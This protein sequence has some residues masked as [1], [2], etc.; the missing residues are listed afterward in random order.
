[1]PTGP[2]RAVTAPSAVFA[3]ESFI[4]ELAHA[5]G[6]DPITF[7]IER[8]LPNR[9]R[10]VRVLEELRRRSAWGT[11]VRPIRG[12]LVGRGVA[13]NVYDGTSFIAMM[14]EVS[15]EA[16]LS[17]LRVTRIITVVDCGLALNP[18]GVDGQT[19]SAIAWGLSAAL[20]GKIDFRNGAAMQSSYRDFPVL[21]IDRM[22]QLE[23]IV[24]NSS[25]EPGG[26]GE[27]PVPLVAPA[28][29]NAIFAAC[30]K[31]VRELPIEL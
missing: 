29:T 5:T 20:Y 3:R 15:L 27:H 2:W 6:K 12:R 9:A 11:S 28:V 10:L 14:A 19:E 24:V 26:Y 30:G 17:D 21:R 7:R 1:M 22:P 4:D 25:E 23:T 8:L 18:L 16:D 13:A 31:R